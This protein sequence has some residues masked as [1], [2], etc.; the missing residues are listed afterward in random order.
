MKKILINKE[1]EE[2]ATIGLFENGQMVELYE[3]DDQ[4]LENN[5]YYGIIRNIL[6]GLQS[7]FVDIGERKNAFIHIKDII[8][9]QSDVTGNK[10][11]KFNQYNI[12]EHLKINMPILVQVKKDAELEKGA[13][14]SKHISLTG[15]FVVLLVNTDFVTVSQKIEDKGEK[16]RLKNLAHEILEE[17]S[18]DNQKFGVIVRTSAIKATPEEIEE[19]VK[20]LLNKWH[21]IVKKY[22]VVK[23]DK[24]P[25]KLCEGG[26]NLLRLIT[27]IANIDDT[28][29]ITNDKEIYDRIKVIEKDFIHT[30]VVVKLKDDFM[31]ICD[32][33]KQL[34]ETRKRKIWLKCGGFITIDK[35]EALTAIDVNS[36]KFIGKRGNCKEETII[37]VNKEAT[38]EIAK[39]LRLR[40]ISGIIIVDYID[41]ES[42]EDREEIYNLFKEQIKKDRSKV[43]LLG[44]TTL[45]LLEITRKKL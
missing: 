35:T 36:G 9:K 5:I 31:Q 38:I 18:G 1:S 2:I 17:V 23:D 42:K 4:D 34:E 6:P 28:E 20:K 14:V 21:E 11:A 39:Q 8:P 44:F 24:K 3:Q 43:Q 10:E 16:A 7:A 29:I 22:E 25:Q 37:K 41:M 32:F 12:R 30:R 13:R 40:N 27:G 26:T 15:R 19:D 33:E 45:D